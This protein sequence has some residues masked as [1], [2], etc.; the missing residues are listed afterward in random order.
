M[1]YIDYVTGWD[2]KRE[3]LASP[4]FSALTEHQ[5]KW[6][7]R[8]SWSLSWKDHPVSLWTPVVAL[9]LLVSAHSF[10]YL[11]RDG[12]LLN[13]NVMQFPYSL[14]V[15][16]LWFGHRKRWDYVYAII[17]ENPKG[18][19]STRFPTTAERFWNALAVFVMA[20]VVLYWAL[21][22][23]LTVRIDNESEYEVHGRLVESGDGDEH[24]L[25]VSP[26]FPKVFDISASRGESSCTLE[27]KAM[28]GVTTT[29]MVARY[30]E[31]GYSGQIRLVVDEEGRVFVKKSSL[32][33][34]PVEGE[35]LVALET[36]ELDERPVV[37]RL[38]VELDPE[39]FS[40]GSAGAED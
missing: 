6:V 21:D 36:D 32:V 14:I 1:K 35:Y 38:R 33:S 39:V 27:L 40:S 12:L 20:A 24:E 17:T 19:P 2:R 16:H 8:K 28:N 37:P 22:R 10:S 25:D 18:F 9:L 26:W 23:D 13:W 4:E 34:G 3:V 5:R 30:Y 15:V 7:L 31:K 11:L 29:Y